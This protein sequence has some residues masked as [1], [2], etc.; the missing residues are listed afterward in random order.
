MS[1]QCLSNETSFSISVPTKM[2]STTY[3]FL[4]LATLTTTA[5]LL[6]CEACTSSS[7]HD[8]YR[9]VRK[10]DSDGKQLVVAVGDDARLSCKTN[11]PWKKC[12]WKPPRNGVREVSSLFSIH[13]QPSTSSRCRWRTRPSRGANEPPECQLRLD[14]RFFFNRFTNSIAIGNWA[15]KSWP[16]LHSRF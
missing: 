14:I 9:V 6:L 3:L 15:H 7:A 2:P 11:I 16:N 8:E 4:T 13:F 12:I 10:S 5:P 1:S